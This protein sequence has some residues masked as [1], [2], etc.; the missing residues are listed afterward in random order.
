[1]NYLTAH[2]ALLERQH[3]RAGQRVV[4]HGAAGGLGTAMVPLARALDAQVVAVVSS[5]AK[6][7]TAR[8]AGAQRELGQPRQRPAGLHGAA[9]CTAAADARTRSAALGRGLR[10][11]LERP[12][13]GLARI[14]RRE[15]TGKVVLDVS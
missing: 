5:A 15:V 10:M 2:F 12:A 3:L 4:V 11:P 6:A 7:E 8:A 14:A 13:E 9:V 1:M